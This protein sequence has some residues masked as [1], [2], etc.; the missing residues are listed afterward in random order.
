MSQVV[1][2]GERFN[3][4]VLFTCLG[5]PGKP[6]V[7][8][9]GPLLL[10]AGDRLLLCSDGLW[11]TRQ[12]QRRSPSS[13]RRAPISDAVPELVEQ[14]LRNGG[15]KSD[16]VTVL[17]VEWEVGRRQRQQPPACPPRALGEEVFASTIQASVLGERLR[18]RARRRRDRALDQRDQRGDQ[19]LVA[20]EEGLNG[21]SLRHS[22]S[23]LLQTRLSAAP[24]RCA[25]AACSIERGYTRHAEGSVLIAVRRHAGAVH[26]VG[27]REGAAAQARQRRGLGHGR[28]RHAAARHAHAQ[29]PRG[30]ARQAERPHAGDPAPDRPLAALRVRPD[31]ARRAHDH[32]RLRRAAGRR[33]H[34]HRGDHRR[35]RRRARRGQLAA[36]AGTHRGRR[37][38]AIIVAAVSVGHRRRARRCSTSSTSKT[39]PATPT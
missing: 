11:G 35:L 39:R 37:R 6:V 20:A 28:V 10:Q 36:R 9:V 13:C 3:R 34:A 27:R 33:R 22:P 26:R 5:S 1:P 16:N 31:G 29:R 38:S 15:A 18:R 24:P 21:A 4:N 17:A 7:D 19:A 32:A 30:R 12:R 8:T 14:A 2:M 23:C 25:A